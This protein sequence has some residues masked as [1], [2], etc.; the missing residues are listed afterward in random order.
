[1]IDYTL[2]W[3]CFSKP[4]KF[5]KKTKGAWAKILVSFFRPSYDEPCYEARQ[6]S[7]N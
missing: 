6:L 1:M 7:L 5:L 3:E 4:F 2:K